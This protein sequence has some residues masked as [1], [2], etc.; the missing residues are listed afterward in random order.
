MRART[1][2]SAVA[3]ASLFIACVQ[4]RQ[5]VVEG[6]LK[7]PR[8]GMKQARG[9]IFLVAGKTPI[10]ADLY[11]MCLSP[12]HFS[13]LTVDSR[14]SS[15]GAGGGL[16][17]VAD[18]RGARTYDHLEEMVAPNRLRPLPGLGSPHAFTPAVSSS[19]MVAFVKPGGRDPKTG[20]PMGFSLR[21]WNARE[22]T[23]RV[24]LSTKDDIFSPEWGPRSQL[25]LV[26]SSSP[27]A[28]KVLLVDAKHHTR[29][30]RKVQ[31]TDGVRL[32]WGERSR[33]LAIGVRNST[34]LVRPKP[35][36]E[37][38]IVKGWFPLA[39]SPSGKELL[40]SNGEVIGLMH[41]SEFGYVQRLGRSRIGTVFSGAWG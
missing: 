38:K 13:R 36:A 11:L 4:P 30:I 9:Q 25:A 1:F 2:V 32:A 31:A 10:A 23:Q 27:R 18:G 17:V 33:W 40:L 21:V 12:I 8:C 37:E 34:I 7:S 19:G 22:M 16:V 3:T 39:W 6:D 20:L 5:I 26:S 29:V 35:Q 41:V 28:T 15:V 24:I 14:I